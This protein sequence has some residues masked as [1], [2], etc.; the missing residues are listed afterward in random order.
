VLLP[1]VYWFNLPDAYGSKKVAKIA[2]AM[3]EDVA[4][5]TTKAAAEKAITATFDLLEDIG[6]PTG[7]KDYNVPKDDIPS[8]SDFVL[9]RAENLYGM[10]DFNPV[11]ANIKNLTGF[12]ERAFEGRESINL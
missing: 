12:F 7:L 5:L 1:F 4:G 10:A 3:G 11:K 6:L 9:S 8:I 2:E